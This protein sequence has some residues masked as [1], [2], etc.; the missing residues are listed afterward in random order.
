MVLTVFGEG[1][2]GKEFEWAAV[3]DDMIVGLMM[4]M[5]HAGSFT[6]FLSLY[7]IGSFARL[8][9]LISLV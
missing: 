9:P 6:L 2:G 5:I 1:L 7:P 8:L 4:M 3:R